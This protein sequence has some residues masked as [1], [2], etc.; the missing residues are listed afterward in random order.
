MNTTMTSRLVMPGFRVTVLSHEP[1]SARRLLKIT[2]LAVLAALL[3]LGAA[4]VYRATCPSFGPATLLLPGH[5]PQEFAYPFQWNKPPP[6][7]FVLVQQLWLPRFHPSTFAF[8]PQDLIWGVEVNGHDIHVEGLPIAAAGHEGRSINL[9]AWLRPGLNIITLHMEVRWR[10]ASL[11]LAVSPWD[12][13][14]LVLLAIAVCATGV[15][16]MFLSALLGFRLPQPEP[17]ILLAG[18]GF[19]YIYAFGTPYFVRSFDSWGHAAYL[20]YVSQHLRLPPPGANWEA[21]QAPLYYLLVGATTRVLLFPGM[22]EEQRFVLWQAVSLFFSVGLLFAGYAVVRILYEK[23]DSRSHYMLAVFAVAPPLVFNATRITNDGLLALLSYTW[24]AL[25]LHYWRQP[26]RAS[27]CGLAAVLGFA[28][29]TKANAIS[30]VL[31]TALCLVCDRRF[32]AKVKVGSVGLMLVFCGAIAGWYYLPRAFQAHEVDTY[33]VGNLHSLGARAHIDDVFIKSLIFNPFKVLRYPFDEPWGPRNDDFLE[34]FFKTLLLGEWIKGAAY[35]FLARWMVLVALA[36]VPIFAVG[37]GG[38]SNGEPPRKN[39]SWPRS[40][41]SSW[42]NGFFFNSRRIFP[43]RTFAT[44]SSFSCLWSIFFLRE[45]RRVRVA[46]NPS[47]P[48]CC[49]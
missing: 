21:F 17:M 9:A 3:W 37:L 38:L 4:L 45:S 10:T 7:S 31:V 15:T 19:R 36:L 11:R 18:I 2:V 46:S 22:A 27:L 42:C 5:A 33:V 23:G 28:L 29:L 12:F 41:G 13:Y 26:N 16:A 25:L 24:L 43:R 44:R 47:R 32:D 34:V 14:R 40:P 8:Y 20:D 30:L 1:K 39:R 49:K 48:F 6:T 35:K